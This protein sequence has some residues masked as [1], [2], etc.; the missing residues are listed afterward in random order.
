MSRQ[1]SGMELTSREALGKG[2]SELQPPRPLLAAEGLLLDLA[3]PSLLDRAVEGGEPAAA[4]GVTEASRPGVAQGGGHSLETPSMTLR[5]S[6]QSTE[7]TIAADMTLQ[8]VKGPSPGSWASIAL[9]LLFAFRRVSFS[10]F[11]LAFS[12]R[13]WL[14]ARRSSSFSS[15]SRSR[16]PRSCSRMATRTPLSATSRRSRSSSIFACCALTMCFSCRMSSSP[17]QR[18]LSSDW[19][20]SSDTEAKS[21]PT[22]ECSSAEESASAGC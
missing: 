14:A 2:G 20:S 19:Y 16:S 1:K 7:G 6:E 10:A 18:R 13:S 22:E 17:F 11:S 9:I 21:T 12:A 8:P 15:P 5:E 4:R 3:A